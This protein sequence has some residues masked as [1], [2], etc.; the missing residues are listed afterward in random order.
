[1]SDPKPKHQPP[2]VLTADPAA[3]K[4]SLAE[5]KQMADALRESELRYRRLFETAKDGILILDADT[6]RIT[7]VN[8]YLEDLLGYTHT[9]ILGRALW[10]IGPFKDVAASQVAFRQLQNTEYIRYENLPLETKGGEHKRQVEFVC[11]VYLVEGK[12]VIQGNVRDIT[13]RKH[14][15]DGLRKANDDLL[16]VVAELQRRDHEMK[17]LNR[18]ND[19]LQTCTTQEEAYRV[20]ALL[21][22]E[23][24][25]GQS[26]SLASLRAWDQFLETVA[27]WGDDAVPEALFSLEDCWAM[28]RGQPYEVVD[29]HAS[30]LCRHFAHEPSTGYLCVPLTVHG[31]TLG[32][33]SLVGGVEETEEHQAG[34][35][36][37]AV[38]VGEAIKLC[39]SNLRLRAKLREQAMIDPLTGLSNRRYLEESLPREL[40][41]ATRTKAALGVAMLDLDHFKRF[42]DTLGHDSG[43][44]LLR[45]VGRVLRERLRK[46]DIAS[47]YGGEEFVLVLPDSS[48][49]NTFQTVEEIRLMIRDLHIRH[50]DQL[51]GTV[52]VS[53]GVAQAREGLT[54]RDLLREAD[55]ALYAAKHAG[56]DRV[57]LYEA[58][59]G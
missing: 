54:A 57:V 35:Q 27:R 42:N 31:E 20:I 49:A 19:L 45:E 46:S 7:D 29:P 10:E 4:S 18:M 56:R 9:E 21:A 36:R 34:R 47:R 16:A 25:P 3:A 28:R 44:S 40:H 43:D 6:G 8:P 26:G 13:D 59:A 15:A 48:P 51:L 1:V 12:K 52:T 5:L 30:L 14:A 24:F 53:A 22:L 55:E 39:L 32:L 37:L 41:R 23:L 58:K 38:T 33:L 11:N 2:K 17:L 50:G